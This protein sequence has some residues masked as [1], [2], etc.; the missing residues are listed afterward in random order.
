SFCNLG[1]II[2]CDTVLR[3][4]WGRFL[5]LPVSLWAIAVFAF[6]VLL[7]LPGAAGAA[8]VGF[9]D[10]ALIG[11]ASASVGFPLVLAVLWWMV[12]RTGC[13]LCL[14]LYVVIAAWF[15]TVAPLARRFQ[16]SDRAPW[17]QRR[18]AAY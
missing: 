8:T 15:V 4:R 12:L 2:N 9:A 7:A 10:L 16:G 5:G 13:L 11:L 14:S 3:S 6:G 17:L 18:V 1:G